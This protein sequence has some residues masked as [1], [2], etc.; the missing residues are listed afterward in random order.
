ML[1]DDDIGVLIDE[2]I[3]A[4]DL[5]GEDEGEISH[6][7]PLEE[8]G[9]DPGADAPL[10]DAAATDPAAAPPKKKQNRLG[11]LNE[12]WVTDPKQEGMYQVNK[13]FE[14]IKLKPGKGDELKT[15]TTVLRKYEYWAQ[16][17]YP[18]FCFKDVVNKLEFMSGKK[19]IRN[20]LT[21]IRNNINPFQDDAIGEENGGD[22]DGAGE[23]NNPTDG[24]GDPGVFPPIVDDVPSTP[25]QHSLGSFAVPTQPVTTSSSTPIAEDMK[26]LIRKKREAA[27]AK[28]KR[29]LEESMNTSTSSS[30]S[31][32]DESFNRWLSW[33]GLCGD[34]LP[35][36]ALDAKHIINFFLALG[37]KR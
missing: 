3:T 1:G 10:G 30:L 11:N 5:F 4:A 36:R 23:L 20:A 8:D 29:K 34:I 26:E 22:D 12:K 33:D 28:R 18:K 6:I 31:Q 17:C 25:T 24:V 2:P 13:Y 7:P 21:A 35:T 16:Q 19:P 14:G 32:A 15:L 37:K 27:I 9:A